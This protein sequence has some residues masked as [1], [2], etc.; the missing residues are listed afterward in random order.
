MRAEMV[1]LTMHQSNEV[2]ILKKY[3]RL[4]LTDRDNISYNYD[5]KI[6]PHFRY[7]M[8]IY[9]KDEMLFALAP[10]LKD[11]K[12]NSRGYLDFEYAGNRILFASRKNAV[13]TSP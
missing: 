4:V 10:E 2:Y 6:Y 5:L 7:C 8:S 9:D 1:E 11:M 12:R 13:I 3:S